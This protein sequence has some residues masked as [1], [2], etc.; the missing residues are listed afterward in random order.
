MCGLRRDALASSLGPLIIDGVPTSP[1]KLIQDNLRDHEARF[2]MVFTDIDASLFLQQQGLQKPLVLVGSDFP[3]DLTQSY[4]YAMLRK[5][6]ARQGY[7]HA[8]VGLMY[9]LLR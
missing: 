3:G 7:A 2:P 1:L 4:D 6:P 8:N 9:L 5:V